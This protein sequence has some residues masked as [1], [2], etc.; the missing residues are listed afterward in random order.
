MV[1]QLIQGIKI[2]NTDTRIRTDACT[3]IFPLLNENSTKLTPFIYNNWLRSQ[4]HSH[5]KSIDT[6]RKIGDVIS[7]MRNIFQYVSELSIDH[8][9]LITALWLHWISFPSLYPNLSCFFHSKCRKNT[10][11]C[12]FVYCARMNIVEIGLILELRSFSIYRLF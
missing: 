7:Q 6:Y 9:H 1:K 10:D 5:K 11:L 3:C 12:V 4:N 8:L 2:T